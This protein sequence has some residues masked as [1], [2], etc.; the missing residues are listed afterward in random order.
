MHDTTSIHALGEAY[1]HAFIEAEWLET[2]LRQHGALV[3]PYINCLSFHRLELDGGEGRLKYLLELG[4]YS[5]AQSVSLA[6]QSGGH[7][8]A[9]RHTRIELKYYLDANG[10]ILRSLLLEEARE[11]HLR[12]LLNVHELRKKPLAS[13]GTDSWVE[14]PVSDAVRFKELATRMLQLRGSPQEPALAALDPP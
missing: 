12:Q 7:A 4:L 10:A 1:R 11:F 8:L 2:Q 14:I 9:K 6:V 5:H 13:N 3:T